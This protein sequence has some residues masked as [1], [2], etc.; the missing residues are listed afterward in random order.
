MKNRRFIGIAAAAAI[1]CAA[2]SFAV[3]D[4]PDLAMVAKIRHEG[5]K[6][7][8]VMK[9]AG[10]LCDV[11][12]PRPTGSPAMTRASHWV[13]DKLKEWGLQNV[14]LEPYHFGVGWA[15]QYISAHLLRP[16]YQP[17]IAISVEWGSSTRGPV[18]GAPVFVD[19][20]THADME[21]YRGRLKNAVV[22]YMPPRPTPPHFT[23]DARRFDD[24]EL[25]NMDRYPIPDESPVDADYVRGF[26]DDLED[27][28][29][30]EEIGVLVRPSS[31]GTRDYGT[32]RAF[33][34]RQAINPERP[35]P[36]PEI[37]LA[38]EHYN[39]IHRLVTEHRE[40][41]EMI[42][43]VRTE[44]YDDDLNGYN[45]VAEIPGTDKK[46]EI[47]MLGG[48][49]DSWSPGTGAADNA[50]GCVVNME[51]VRILKKLGVKPRRTIRIVLWSAEEKGWLGSKA[52]VAEHF[53]EVETMTLK[54]G[55]AKLSAY[56]NYDNGTGRIRGIRTQ[57]N[58]QIRPIFEKWMRPFHDLGMTQVVNLS[59]MGSDHGALDLVGLPSF[60]WIQ[61]PIH[62][63]T[64]IHHTNMD[65]V[66]HLIPE[67]LIQSAVIIAS[68][69]YH[70][71]MREEMLP[72]KPLPAPRKYPVRR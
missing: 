30:E 7:S 10:Y 22:L 15:P 23:P 34:I 32:V 41:C 5:I 68:F 24:E 8:Q 61:D 20:K 33:G 45:V 35:R 28:F 57:N 58:I 51:A 2:F 12:G 62:Y 64:R 36:L 48:H 31:P 1:F 13:L 11:I 40:S 54:P 53:G 27:F 72:R 26:I 25:K 63:G 3:Q 47:V 65:V 16:H 43:E 14:R 49:L 29:R 21:K 9:L 70:T 44:F 66:D 59:T 71:A 42:V 37:I 18:T 69:V 6:N 60:Q 50:A 19:I 39:L 38:T 17:L 52:Y 67:D 46:D 4:E 55:H 56:F